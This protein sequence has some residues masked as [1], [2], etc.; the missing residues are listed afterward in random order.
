M[1]EWMILN[2]S[3]LVHFLYCEFCQTIC[4]SFKS[5]QKV[6]R[7]IVELILFEFRSFLSCYNEYGIYFVCVYQSERTMCTLDTSISARI[8]SS[9]Y[10]LYNDWLHLPVLTN[11]LSGAFDS[12]SCFATTSFTSSSSILDMDANSQWNILSN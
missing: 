8:S 7:R 9:K 11:N 6:P 3:Q 5:T 10:S 12:H 2:S 1:N 4:G